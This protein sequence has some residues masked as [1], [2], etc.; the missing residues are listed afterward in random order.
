MPIH[1]IINGVLIILVVI[2]TALWLRTKP[3]GSDSSI[4]P[5]KGLE[6]NVDIND[7]LAIPESILEPIPY[8]YL[9]ASQTNSI[10]LQNG[11]MYQIHEHIVPA[12]EVPRTLF[13]HMAPD[14]FDPV[15]GIT[16]TQVGVVRTL[17][18][19]TEVEID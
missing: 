5:S 19:N 17:E 4:L 8:K 15:N 13:H 7:P 16:I 2:N 1:L 10:T 11:K 14:G 18:S 3:M 12:R 9:G 6:Y